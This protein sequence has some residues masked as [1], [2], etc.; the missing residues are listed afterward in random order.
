MADTIIALDR[1]NMEPML[2]AVGLEFPEER[3][4]TTLFHFSNQILIA[5]VDQ[6]VFGYV[7]Y[8]DDPKNPEDLYLSSIQIETEHR[9]GTL[10]KFLVSHLLASL[11]SKSFTR[12][13]TQIQK[14]NGPMIAIAKKAGFTL[15]ENPKK[16]ATLEAFAERHLLDSRMFDRL[17]RL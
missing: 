3:R 4:R 8:C 5:K 12:I 6:E 9:G 13:R 1:R 7:D 16:S 17:F 15:Q 10:F 2:K 11:R 14:S